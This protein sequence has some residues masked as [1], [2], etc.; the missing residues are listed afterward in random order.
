[1]TATKAF[2]HLVRIA[3]ILALLGV[4]VPLT[5]WLDILGLAAWM[6]GALV[7]VAVLE[8]ALLRS[9]VAAAQGIK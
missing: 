4:A 2:N 8:R 9:R 7:V 5:R 1:M 3:G 6:T